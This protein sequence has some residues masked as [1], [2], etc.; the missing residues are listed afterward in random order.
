MCSY[1]NKLLVLNVLVAFLPIKG[2]SHKW[3]N[4]IVTCWNYGQHNEPGKLMLDSTFCEAEVARAATKF[5]PCFLNS[6]NKSFYFLDESSI[7]G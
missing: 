3:T 5:P 4:G 7:G 6:A 1:V 2:A